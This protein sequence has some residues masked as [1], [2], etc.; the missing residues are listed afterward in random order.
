VIGRTELLK[1]AKAKYNSYNTNDWIKAGFDEFSGGYQVYHKDHFFDPT[2]GRFGIPR[3][4]YERNVSEV[5]VKYGNSVVLCSEKKEYGA[6]TPDG[7]LNN[8][9]FD[10]KGIEGNSHRTIKDAI[11][12]AS[13]QGVEIVVLYFNDKNSFNMDFVRDG[14]EKYLTNSKSKRVKKVYCVVGKHLYKL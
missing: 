3:G 13:K 5:L 10:I 9:V 4:D 7:L 2:I 6:K 8:I 1:E 11:L 14:Y 12:K